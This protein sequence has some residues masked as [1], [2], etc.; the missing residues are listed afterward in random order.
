MEPI[1]SCNIA[2]PIEPDDT[3]EKIRQHYIDYHKHSSRIEDGVC[4]NGCARLIQY[5][6]HLGVVTCPVC[7]FIGNGFELADGATEL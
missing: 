5:G 2:M 4:P 6:D 1:H 3:L 7:D